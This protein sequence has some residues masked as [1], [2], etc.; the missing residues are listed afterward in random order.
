M[1]VGV[2]L[3]A[4][5]VA[6]IVDEKDFPTFGDGV[7]WAIV[8]LA[9]VGYG[10]IVPTTMTGR[11]VGSG[12]ILFGITFLSFLTAIVTSLFVS[13]EQEERGAAERAD[14]DEDQAE[15]RALLL[16]LDRRLA[17]IEAKLER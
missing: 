13:T 15:T 16:Q 4:G 6:T 3:L 11:I 17:A 9:T 8:T 10:D 12:L 2:G 7:W 14:R 1:T 5:F